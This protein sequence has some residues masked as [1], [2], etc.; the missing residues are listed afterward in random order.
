MDLDQIM[1]IYAGQLEGGVQREKTFKDRLAERRQFVIGQEKNA[2]PVFE[3]LMGGSV[4]GVKFDLSDALNPLKGFTTENNRI[5]QYAEDDLASEQKSNRD[6]LGSIADLSLKKAELDSKGAGTGDLADLVKLRETLVAQG[7]DTTAVD[8]K[9]STYGIKPSTEIPAAKQEIIDVITKLKGK[10]IGAIT[11]TLRYGDT[12]ASL[13][14]LDTKKESVDSALLYEQLKAMLSLENR[15]KL[16]GSGQISD[17]ES[18]VLARAASSLDR[19]QSEDNF[20]AVLNELET[21]LSGG[22]KVDKKDD[23]L[24]LF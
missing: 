4:N 10:D 5:T 16:K 23:P 19:K 13:N 2:A 24:G 1:K 21:K 14:P 15:Q 6:L 9:L 8:A 17:Y 11:G 20:R 3:G 22:K 12:V 18:R 7:L